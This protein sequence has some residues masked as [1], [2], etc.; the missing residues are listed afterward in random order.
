MLLQKKQ[1]GY[2]DMVLLAFKTSVFY[3]LFHAVVHFI[4]AAL[5]VIQIIILAN[6]INTAIS[7]YQQITPLYAIVGLGVLLLALRLYT[8]LSNIFMGLIGIKRDIFFRNKIMPTVIEHCSKLHYKYIESHKAQ[9]IMG[10]IFSADLNV[11]VWEMYEQVINLTNFAIYTIGVISMLTTTVW[12]AGLVMT[13][14]TLPLLYI[15]RK[16]G[17]RSYTATR[18]MTTLDR[19]ANYLSSLMIQRETVEERTIFGF[20]EHL[21]QQYDEYFETPRKHRLKADSKNYIMQS[22]SGIITVVCAVLI[23]LILIQSVVSEDIDVGLYIGLCIAIFGLSSRFW[24]VSWNIAA[25]SRNREYL[26]DLS[27]FMQFEIY[28]DKH[29]EHSALSFECIEF[30]NVRFAY[31]NDETN[32]KTFVLDGVSFFIEKGKHYAFVGENGAG[33][34]TIAKLLTGL[35]DNYEG[36]IFIDGKELRNFSRQELNSIV[37]VVFQDFARYSMPL[38]DNIILSNPNDLHMQAKTKEAISQFALSE[39]IA[40]LPLGANTPLGKVYENG[41]DISGG[42]WQRIAMARS[43][44][45]PTPLK[46]LDEPTASQDPV[47]ES[48]IYQHYREISKECTTIFIS[49]RLGST[50]LADIIFVLCKGKIAEQGNHANLMENGGLYTKMYESQAEWY[51]DK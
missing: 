28:D 24:S 2:I 13:L 44:V 20:T 1:Y 15:A 41:V 49:H 50:K 42:E 9:D 6:F 21:N 47:S 16:A 7:V 23:M 18:E 48:L 26:S 31:P 45:S 40:K 37:S 14:S 4:G 12:W 25:I 39:T 3:S 38:I 11:K 36:E 5:P 19:R 34:T 43:F 17:I 8:A 30:R 33:K 51:L 29:T 10:R 46:I 27:A 32:Q 22:L 35:Y